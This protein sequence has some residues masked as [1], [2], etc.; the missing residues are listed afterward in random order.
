MLYAFPNKCDSKL[1]LKPNF[2]NI[3]GIKAGKLNSTILYTANV[4]RLRKC[5]TRVHWGI[6]ITCQKVKPNSTSLYYCV[7]IK[8]L[9]CFCSLSHRSFFKHLYI[10]KLLYDWTLC[11]VYIINRIWVYI[12]LERVTNCSTFQY[13]VLKPTHDNKNFD[14]III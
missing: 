2:A 14:T 5:K 7:L 6:W 12:F 10:L 3:P 4:N 9:R 13:K 8:P 11:T 1:T